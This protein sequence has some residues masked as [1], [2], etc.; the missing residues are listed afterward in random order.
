MVVGD[1]GS[2]KSRSYRYCSGWKQQHQGFD[3]TREACSLS[4]VEILEHKGQ[5]SKK[6]PSQTVKSYGG[7]HAGGGAGE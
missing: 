6:S 7:S 1:Q 4:R 3:H 2:L 5:M